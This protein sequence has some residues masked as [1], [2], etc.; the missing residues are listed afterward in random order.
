MCNKNSSDPNGLCRFTL[1]VGRVFNTRFVVQCDR[2]QPALFRVGFERTWG[3]G[4]PVLVLALTMIVFIAASSS[5]LVASD[6]APPEDRATEVDGSDPPAF[7]KTGFSLR[8]RSTMELWQDRDRY[9]EL[10]LEGVRS[11]D[12]ETNER[13]RWVIE[14]WQR[15]IFVDTPLDIAERLVAMDPVEAIELLLELGDFAPATLALEEAVGTLEY[16]GMASRLAMTLN[17][18]FPIYARKA[19]EQDTQNDLLHFWPRRSRRRNWRSA[20]TIGIVCSAGMA[21]NRSGRQISK[22]ILNSPIRFSVCSHC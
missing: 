16:E 13:A 3:L 8:R 9:R 7:D 14:R 15:G 17:T 19:I 5:L 11:A 22:R 10:V 2:W 12:L 20:I 6:E 1:H 18:R 21:T 4:S